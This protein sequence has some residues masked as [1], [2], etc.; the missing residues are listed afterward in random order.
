M[1]DLSY[2]MVDQKEAEA[3]YKAIQQGLN[4]YATSIGIGE[5]KNVNLFCYD[6]NKLIGG[7]VAQT[8]QS[9]IN[10]KWLWVDVSYRKR[11]IGR[12]LMD[13]IEQHAKQHECKYSFVDTMSY[14][15]PDFYTKLGYAEVARIVDFYPG[16]DRVF[17]RK[18][19]H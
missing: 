13:K 14:Q 5:R 10:V 18:D 7:I 6:Q 9:R 8:I 1:I 17:F 15:A 11:N 4:E 12:Q 16:H 19:L 3:E 2:R